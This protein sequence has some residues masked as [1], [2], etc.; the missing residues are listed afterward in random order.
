MYPPY[1]MP[2][3]YAKQT[4]TH[5]P[6]ALTKIATGLPA[7]QKSI[8]IGY[9]TSNPDNQLVTNLFRLSSRRPG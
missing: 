9:D 6:S 3:Q 8:T 2:A 5:D 4:L 7:D 1:M